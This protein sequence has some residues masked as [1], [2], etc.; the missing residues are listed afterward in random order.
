MSADSVSNIMS[1]L[2]VLLESSP[3]RCGG[4][5]G[6]S[7][8]QN[9]SKTS[10]LLSS[11]RFS[12]TVRTT[13]CLPGASLAGRGYGMGHCPSLKSKDVKSSAG[14]ATNHL[15]NHWASVSPPV[16]WR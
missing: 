4:G 2:T 1:P 14:S 13:V 16:K 9:S 11:S 12:F 10:Q 15:S 8:E 6:S 7:P 3:G 5:V